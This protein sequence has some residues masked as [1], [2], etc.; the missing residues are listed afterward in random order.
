MRHDSL[1]RTTTLSLALLLPVTTGCVAEWHDNDH[2]SGWWHDGP[3]DGDQCGPDEVWDPVACVCL[4]DGSANDN[5]N[6]GGG[7]NNNNSNNNNGGG[8]NGGNNNN[9]GGGGG[10]GTMCPD[11]M[12]SLYLSEDAAAC[13]IVE[14]SCPDGYERFVIDGCGC[15]CELVEALDP[16]PTAEDGDV[17]FVSR[18]ATVCGKVAFECP[19]GD[20]QFYAECGCG[21]ITPPPEPVCPSQDDP[22]VHYLN[23]DPTVCAAITF[24]CDPG[25]ERFDN[26]CGCGCIEP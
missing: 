11:P 24:T 17:L 8:G 22:K 3:M 9:N 16:C 14:F 10:G 5:N 21:C 2:D 1:I 6:N 18:D 26:E 15:G 25:C 7:G 20:T 23:T 4:P 13:D 12:A 19:E